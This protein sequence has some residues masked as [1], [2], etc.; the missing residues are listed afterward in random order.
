MEICNMY[1]QINLALLLIIIICIQSTRIIFKYEQQVVRTK[2]YI[3]ASH[4]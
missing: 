1:V 2:P 3:V 4:Q